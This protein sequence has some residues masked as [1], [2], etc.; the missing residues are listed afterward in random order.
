MQQMMQLARAQPRLPQALVLHEADDMFV[1]NSPRSLSMLTLVV[2]LAADA[3]ELASPADAQAF[4]MLL[5]EDLPRGFFT[6][7]TP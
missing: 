2:R 3:H 4:D 1:S 7:D 6:T 5:R